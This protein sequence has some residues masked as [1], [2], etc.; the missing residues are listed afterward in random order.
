MVLGLTQPL[1]KMMGKGGWCLG[2]TTL[3][4]TGADSHEIWKSHSPGTIKAFSGLYR[5]CFTFTVI[6]EPEGIIKTKLN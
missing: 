1:T 4:N 5:V 6:L 3:P 2:L